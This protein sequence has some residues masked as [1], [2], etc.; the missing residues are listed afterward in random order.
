MHFSDLLRALPYGC[1]AL[2]A[3]LDNHMD[4]N[5]RDAEH[6]T[7]LMAAAA[8]GNLQAV[9]Y[10]LQHGADATLVDKSGRDAAAWA[11]LHDYKSFPVNDAGEAVLVPDYE[12]VLRCLKLAVAAR[13][14]RFQHPHV[15]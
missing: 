10:L 14:M 3:V 6:R 2:G 4:I 12:G 5:A 9:E 8:C 11:E 15:T 13:P 7:V 1:I